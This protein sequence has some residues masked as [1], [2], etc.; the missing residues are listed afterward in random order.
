[1][2]P[3]IIFDKS[4]LEMLAVDEAC[5]LDAH[6]L[7]N[8][9]PLFFVETLADLQ[10]KIAKGRTPEQVVGILAEKLPPQAGANVHHRTLCI[11]ELLG[12]P[13]TMDRRPVI[14][15]GQQVVTGDQRGI[16]FDEPPE[17][18]ALSRWQDGKFLEVEREIAVIWRRMRSG[19][20]LDEVYQRY[21]CK[22]DSFEAAKAEADRLVNKHGSR[23]TNLKFAFQNLDVPEGDRKT[24]F[25]RWKAAG[26]PPLFS[27][28]PYT[29]HVLTVDLFFN[30]AIGADLISR[31]RPSNKVDIAYLYYLPFCMIFASNDKLHAR[32]ATCFLRDDQLFISGADLKTDLAKL[33]A[34]YSQLPEDVKIRG[35]ISFASRPPHEGFLTTD[36]WD[37]FMRPDWRIEHEIPGAK[38]KDAKLLEHMKRFIDA[39]R[40][41]RGAPAPS[42]KDD[43]FM[44]IRS[45]VPARMGKWRLVPPEVER[46]S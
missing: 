13:V 26:G 45:S 17:M 38:K 21:R 39:A 42:D 46:H 41:Q 11:G 34:F 35:V 22:M 4:A 27:F 3:I 20:N 44:L 6:Y 31:D 19:I 2:G 25:A 30:I 36:L 43:D 33:D 40:K 14:G 28:A 7:V 37:R 18:K 10:K 5:W 15:G 16:F 1:V 32:T 8:I 23:F 24:I 9:T 12:Y 29:A